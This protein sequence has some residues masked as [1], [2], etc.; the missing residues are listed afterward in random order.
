M[1]RVAFLGTAEYGVPILRAL[2]QHHQVV[3]VV[4]QPDRYGGRGRRRLFQ[5]PVKRVAAAQGIPILQPAR[6]SKDAQA[7]DALAA[8]SCDVFVLAAYGQILRPAVL[9]LPRRGVIGV[10]ASLLPRWRGAAPV[11][12]AIRA[13][14]TETGVSLMLTEEGLDT[15]PII[16]SERLAILPTDTTGTLTER[17]AHL[18]ADL[19]LSTLP[20]WLA[21]EIEP[22]PQDDEQGTYAPEISK[23]DGAIDWGQSAEE[24]ERHVRAMAPW[25]GAYTEIPGG[26]RLV[27]WQARPDLEKP[28]QLAPGTVVGTSKELAVATGRGLLVLERVQ[29]AGGRV[30][31]G[32]DFL[33]GQPALPGAILG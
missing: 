32:A 2:I 17:L 29:P 8:A 9:A 23:T 21:G 25:P 33:R 7:L 13:G 10:H 28:T 31:S 4:T 22:S 27:I 30:M 16:A 1:A 19:L 6:L 11:A 3:L 15:G 24:I 14:D 20:A 18:G 5:S 26:Y 12:A